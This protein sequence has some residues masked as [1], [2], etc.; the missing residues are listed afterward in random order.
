MSKSN[1]WL[2]I[3]FFALIV[4]ENLIQWALA[5]SVGEHTIKSGFNNAFEYFTL[6][7]YLFMTLFRLVPYIS[8]ALILSYLS[9]TGFKDYCFPVFIGGLIG[10]LSFIIY[11]LWTSQHAYYTDEHVSSTTP[12]SFLFIPIYAVPV[13][14][15]SAIVLAIIYTPV[16]YFILKHKKT[17]Q[18]SAH[19]STNRSESKFL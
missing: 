12:I 1:Y 8:L 16:R 11:G 7:G 19:Q 10:I 15:L 18:D 4:N 13:G 14:L 6:L 5:V 3:L 2:P 17:E 9:R